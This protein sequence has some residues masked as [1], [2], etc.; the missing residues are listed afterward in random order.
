M[1]SSEEEEEE[2]QKK[3]QVD[4][5]EKKWQDEDG[6]EKNM[7][8]INALFITPGKEIVILIK[9]FTNQNSFKVWIEK[10]CFLQ[11]SISLLID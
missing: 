8:R 9:S 3:G 7:R 10:Y 6:V 2:G 5:G 1:N 4:E 11:P